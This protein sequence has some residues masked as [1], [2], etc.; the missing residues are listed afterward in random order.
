M[1]KL[2][3]NDKRHLEAAEGWLGLGNYLEA[4]EE[5]ER[6][7]PELRAHPDVLT[8]RY[9]VYAKGKKWEVAAEIA[10]ALTKIQ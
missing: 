8:L 5:L 9:E 4:N 10:Q 3:L 7:T 1:N 6:I 2:E